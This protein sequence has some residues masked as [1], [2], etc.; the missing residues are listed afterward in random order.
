M[1]RESTSQFGR[2]IRAYRQKQGWTQTHAA[3]LMDVQR[4]SLNRWENGKEMPNG[5]NMTKLRDH[6]KL[7][8]GTHEDVDQQTAESVYQLILPFN[9]AVGLELRVIPKTAATVQIQVQIKNLAS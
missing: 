5:E 1:G 4:T 3:K 2:R 6:L 7:P 9:R 8:I